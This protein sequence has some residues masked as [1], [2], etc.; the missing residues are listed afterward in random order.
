MPYGVLLV[1]DH[2]ILRD[3]IRAI[4]ELTTEFKVVADTGNGSSAVALCRKLQP[5]VV[6]MDLRLPGISGIEATRE[7]VQRGARAKVI[8]LTMDGDENSVLAALRSGARGFVL[9]NGSSADL[10]DALRTVSKGGCY[11]SADVS[12]HL[13]ARIRRGDLDSNEVPDPIALL[14]PRERQLLRM[15]ASGKTS[16]DIANLLRLAPET[17]RTYRRTLMKKIGVTNAAALTQAAFSAGLITSGAPPKLTSGPDRTC[18]ADS[19]RPSPEC[20]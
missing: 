20:C 7:I 17:V 2:K 16:K 11:L 6:I 12:D 18:I 13:L 4:L 5:D 8:I 9:K 19:E 15:I 10:L 14:A 3:G 1:D